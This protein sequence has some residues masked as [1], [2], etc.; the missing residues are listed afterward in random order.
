MYGIP[1]YCWHP[2]NTFALNLC[3]SRDTCPNLAAL[4]DM[5]K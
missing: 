3:K 2:G 5:V 1:M 4:K